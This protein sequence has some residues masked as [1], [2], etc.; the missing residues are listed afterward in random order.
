[1]TSLSEQEKGIVRFNGHQPLYNTDIRLRETKEQNL[2]T[3]IE[4]IRTRKEVNENE[5]DE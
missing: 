2:T 4:L 5:E 1:M 3:L